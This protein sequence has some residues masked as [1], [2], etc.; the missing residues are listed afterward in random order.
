MIAPGAALGKALLK[1]S[2]AALTRPTMEKE[3]SGGA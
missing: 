3:S 2:R 1:L